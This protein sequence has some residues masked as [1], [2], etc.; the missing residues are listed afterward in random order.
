MITCKAAPALA[1]DCTIVIKGPGRGALDLPGVGGV[2]TQGWI[3][4]RRD[5]RHH[6]PGKHRSRRQ[7]LDDG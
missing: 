4:C 7:A 3:P 5:Q 1:A 2:G 6:G